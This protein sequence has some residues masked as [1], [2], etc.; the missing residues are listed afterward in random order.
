MVMK[1]LFVFIATTLIFS[2]PLANEPPP[3]SAS[4]I[5]AIESNVVIWWREIHQH[6]EL[7]NRESR[8]AALIADHLRSLALDTIQ[9]DVAHTGGVATLIGHLPGSAIALRADQVSLDCR[10]WGPAPYTQIKRRTYLGQC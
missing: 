8:T 2:T 3:S 5:A 10:N 6:R 7:S 1:A 4:A 9:T